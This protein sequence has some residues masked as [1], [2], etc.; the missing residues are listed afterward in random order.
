MTLRWLLILLPATIFFNSCNFKS[1]EAYLAESKIAGEKGD[2][3]AAIKLLDNAID[4][5]PTLKEAYLQRGRCFENVHQEESAISD[6]KKVL[7]IDPDNT[8]AFYYAGLCRFRQNKF[9]A[10]IEFYN[11]ALI[12]K[13]VPN[14]SD[15]T[16][17]LQ[18]TDPNKNG[19]SAA[20]DV[21]SSKIYYERGLAYYKT[22]QTQRAYRDFQNCIAQQYNLDECFYM[23]G[24]CLQAVNKNDKACESFKQSSTYGNSMAKNQ[25]DHLC[26]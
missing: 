1:A 8:T 2:Y 26:K 20:F 7:D 14:P 3:S 22:L 4:K 5:N 23:S 21:P 16:T 25:L 19:M 24:L 18:T 15:T 17:L 12:T 6:Y 9:D 10:A 11:K 13:G